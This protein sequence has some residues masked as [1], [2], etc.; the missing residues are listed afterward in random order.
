[1]WQANKVSTL[2]E[3][4][5]IETQIVGIK[6]KGDKSLGGNLASSVG[7]FIHAVDSKLI[8][9]EIDIAVHSSKDV[10]VDMV[11][12]I[13]NIAYLERGCTN[14]LLI[15]PSEKNHLCLEDLLQ[16]KQES[17]L[18]DAL[19]SIPKSGKLP[20]DSPC[21]LQ[22]KRIY[23]FPKVFKNFSIATA[24]VPCISDIRP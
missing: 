5:G 20:S 23:P 14:D 6:S 7:Q 12:E 18:D 8:E 13:S 17:S 11:D 9:K 15:F 1:M 2:L 4:E 21:P 19:A 16:S 24:F 3:S 22:L 10:P